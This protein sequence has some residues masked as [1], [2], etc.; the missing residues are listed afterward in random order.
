M[1]SLRIIKFLKN[2]DIKKIS[3]N[4]ALIRL[5]FLKNFLLKNSNLCQN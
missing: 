3:S 1:L 5:T 4:E 2:I